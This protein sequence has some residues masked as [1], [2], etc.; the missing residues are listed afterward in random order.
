MDRPSDILGYGDRISGHIPA[1]RLFDAA[2]AE[3]LAGARCVIALWSNASLAS[4]WVIEE[5]ADARDRS[6]LVPVF[7]E[8]VRPPADLEELPISMATVRS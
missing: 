1:G 2:I 6:I 4:P 3:Q 8:S 5:A 7:V